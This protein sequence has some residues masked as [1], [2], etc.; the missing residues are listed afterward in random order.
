MTIYKLTIIFLIFI[1][2]CY[3]SKF[4]RGLNS[5]ELELKWIELEKLLEVKKGINCLSYFRLMKSLASVNQ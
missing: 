4:I 2:N 5:D 3:L 1:C